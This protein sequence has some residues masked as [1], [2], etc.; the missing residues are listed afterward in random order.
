MILFFD[1]GGAA[2][3]ITL[4]ANTAAFERQRLR[5]RVSVDVA[6]VDTATQI[7]GVPAALPLAIAP[8]GA[9]DVSVSPRHLDAGRGL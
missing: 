9:S 8:T 3:E 5:P 7:L 6:K 2:D 4:R 1:S